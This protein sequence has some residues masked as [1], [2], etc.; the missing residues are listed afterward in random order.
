MKA[1]RWESPRPLHGLCPCPTHM[2]PHMLV[3]VSMHTHICSH[4]CTLERSPPAS[5]SNSSVP[6]APRM[7]PGT[8]RPSEEIFFQRMEETKHLIGFP[9]PTLTRKPLN[10][11]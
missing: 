3:C 11:S 7:L 8:R 1:G 6:A 9:A 4:T 10:L 2:Y 5:V